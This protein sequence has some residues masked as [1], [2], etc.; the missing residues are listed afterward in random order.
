MSTPH[1]TA[2]WAMTALV[3][4]CILACGAQ[5]QSTAI[6]LW[7]NGAPRATGTD[8]TDKPAIMPFPAAQPNGAAAVIFPGGGYQRLA[9]EK[10]GNASA[11]WLSK[12]GV[13]AFVVRSRLGMKYHHPVEMWDAQRAI[14]WVRAHAAQ[15]GID[16]ARVGVVGFSAGGHLA[17][18]VSTHFD[19][20]NPAATDS[21]D[22]QSCRPAF[23]VLGYPVITMDASFTHQSSRDY[24]LGPNPSQA[25]VD[26]LSNEK[27]VTAQTP[28]AFLFHAT[29]DHTVPIKNSQ[30]Y[31][32]SLVKRGVTASL[33]KF[34]HGGHGFGLADGKASSPNDP[35]LHTWCD[36]SVKWLDKLGFFKPA[37]ISVATPAAR[38]RAQTF[39]PVLRIQGREG[40]APDALGRR[41]LGLTPRRPR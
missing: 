2:L 24:L 36:S 5:A 31:H 12:L 7:P 10:E 38:P 15:Y 3:L 14:R 28:P 33:M 20:G 37:T 13:A 40:S 1:P 19:A 18:T 17:A 4:I 39:G 41:P 26:S 29:D 11:L 23:S 6:L 30:V 25:V 8:S 32:D 9:F 16:T 27:W 21:V 22:R 34:D 35:V